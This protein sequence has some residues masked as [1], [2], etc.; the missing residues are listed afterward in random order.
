MNA[1]LATILLLGFVVGCSKSGGSG[2]GSNSSGDVIS[3][4]QQPTPLDIQ[5]RTYV[6]LVNRDKSTVSRCVMDPSNGGLNQCITTGNGLNDPIGISVNNDFAYIANNK[7]WSTGGTISVCQIDKTDATLNNCTEDNPDK[8]TFNNVA[9][10]TNYN[11]YL[12]VTNYN[13]AITKCALSSNG[14]YNSCKVVN[15]GVKSFG[16]AI[17]NKLAYV[18]NYDNNIVNKCIINDAD[19]SIGTCSANKFSF[20]KPNGIYFSNNIVY[21]ASEGDSKVYKCNVTPDGEFDNCSATGADNY[22]SPRSINLINGFAYITSISSGK[23]TICKVKSSDN[24]LNDCNQFR[25]ESFG[26]FQEGTASYVIATSSTVK[27]AYA[28]VSANSLNKIFYCNVNLATNALSG[29][30]EAGSGFNSPSALLIN[31]NNLYIG[32]KNNGNITKCLIGADY[33]LSGCNVLSTNA[34]YSDSH[35][36]KIVGKYLYLTSYFNNKIGKCVFNDV[37]GSISGCVT[38]GDDI[39]YPDSIEF[40]GSKAYISMGDGRH[41]ASVCNVDPTTGNIS[42]C[43]RSTAFGSGWSPTLIDIINITNGPSYIY[44]PNEDKY[45]SR[46]VIAA[47]GDLSDCKDSEAG[48]SN[49]YQVKYFNGKLYVMSRNLGTLSSCEVNIQTGT[50]S[51]CVRSLQDTPPAGNG[52]KL[53]GFAVSVFPNK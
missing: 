40:K 28:Y 11:N 8:T 4:N 27:A 20:L 35:D 25:D 53:H 13:G 39:V 1:R 24:N 23:V 26:N 29:C 43:V 14:S 52:S 33:N 37:D 47:N 17:A 48:I 15:T 12:Y 32:N 9:G 38:T 34:E 19:G 44:I 22:F 41:G 10:V 3:I 18:T 42:G 7:K 5:K 2:G 6:Y 21:V 30:E 16:I 49:P 36:I 50:L 51:N 31:G 46:C 45:L